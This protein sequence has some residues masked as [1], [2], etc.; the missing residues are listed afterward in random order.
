MKKRKLFFI[1]LMI[2]VFSCVCTS[3]IMPMRE[4]VYGEGDTWSTDNVTIKLNS[5]EYLVNNLESKVELELTFTINATGEYQIKEDD[6]Y[7]YTSPDKSFFTLTEKNEKLNGFDILNTTI[8]DETQYTFCFELP[9][10]I[11]MDENNEIIKGLWGVRCFINPAN[12]RI[13]VEI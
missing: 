1:I 10:D 6:L 7:V 2:I 11:F 3:C 5:F 9:F 8:T 12:F 4:P 13:T